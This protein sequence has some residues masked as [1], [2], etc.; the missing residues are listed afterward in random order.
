LKSIELPGH[1]NCVLLLHGLSGNPLEMQHLSKRFHNE[2]FAV[3]CPTIPGFG[4]GTRVNAFDSGTW[5]EWLASVVA[6]FD[7]LR[8][9]YERV[10]VGGL[11]IGAVLALKLASLRS[12]D[13]ASLALISTTLAYDG[14]AMPWYSFLVPLGYHTPLRYRISWP[15]RE[16]FGVKNL[17]LRE[18]IKRAMAEHGD[19]PAGAAR[20]PLSGIHQAKRLIRDVRRNIKH[21]TSPALVLHAFDDDVASTKSAEFVARHV[22]SEHVRTVLFRDSYH[23]LTIDNDKDLVADEAIAFVRQHVG[24]LDQEVA[25]ERHARASRSPLVLVG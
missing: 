10:S 12:R 24:L 21:V 14:W 3:H 4:F 20:L 6:E 8:Y 23:M 9:R 7:R 1:R 11:C 5:E 15:E 17:R 19:S 25:A 13:I 16:P 2:G 18:W 22:G